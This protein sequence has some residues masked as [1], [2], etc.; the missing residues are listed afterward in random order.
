MPLRY[1]RRHKKR[2][3]VLKDDDILKLF[4]IV[5]YDQ[6]SAQR[7]TIGGAS[8]GHQHG[9][10]LLSSRDIQD[11]CP[12]CIELFDLED[13]VYELT[14]QHIYHSKCLYPWL[15]SC[16][17]SCPLCKMDFVALKEHTSTKVGAI[18]Q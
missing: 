18:C 14:C 4:S 1:R 11:T 16:S 15:T 6:W 10:A 9:A 8:T 5:K 12:I 2:T 13:K 17:A 3:K 7:T